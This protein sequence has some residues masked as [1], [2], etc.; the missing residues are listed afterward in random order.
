MLPNIDMGLSTVFE[1]ENYYQAP[2]QPKAKMQS[3]SPASQPGSPVSV[4]SESS[5][6]SPEAKPSAGEARVRRPLNA[7]IIW[8]KEERRR[9]AALNPE[10]EN[11]DLSKILG[12]IE[13][14]ITALTHSFINEK[15]LVIN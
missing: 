13:N 1:S 5:C 15:R 2:S 7:F 14:E 12:K 9:L 10:L 8:T 11:T 4:E 6:S 3:N